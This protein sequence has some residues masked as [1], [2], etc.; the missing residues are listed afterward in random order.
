MASRAPSA[1]WMTFSGAPSAPARAPPKLTEGHVPSVPPPPSGCAP[2]EK[3]C[4]H[5]QNFGMKPVREINL[6]A[7]YS[8]VF[9]LQT[10]KIYFSLIKGLQRYSREHG[11]W[12][13]TFGTL[14]RGGAGFATSSAKTESHHR[15]PHSIE[16]PTD[17]DPRHIKTVNSDNCISVLMSVRFAVGRSA[18]LKPVM[19]LVMS[20][21]VVAPVA[22]APLRHDRTAAQ[23]CW[24]A[25]QEE[26]QHFQRVTCN[27]VECFS[28]TCTSDHRQ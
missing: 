23:K 2:A 5:H 13:W 28:R 7:F 16:D 27:W 11:G 8:Y 4:L 18:P 20:N 6:T 21:L 1:P 25:N 17:A 19:I 10:Q 12:W 14:T 24:S 15:V 3:P 26:L 22:D 9:F